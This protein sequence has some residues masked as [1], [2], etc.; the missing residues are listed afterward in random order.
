MSFPL[1]LFPAFQIVEELET[2]QKYFKLDDPVYKFKRTI[3][4]II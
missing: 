1:Q 3:T 2:Y 4:R